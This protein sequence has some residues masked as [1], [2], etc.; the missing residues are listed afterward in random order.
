M[1]RP[2][3]HF[4]QAP[5]AGFPPFP[6]Q[7][8][9]IHCPIIH[10]PAW[11]GGLLKWQWFS[12]ILTRCKTFPSLQRE[13]LGMGRHL[14]SVTQR[15]AIRIF[16]VELNCVIIL[17]VFSLCCTPFIYSISAYESMRWCKFLFCLL[18]D[19]K[20]CINVH[21]CSDLNTGKIYII[22]HFMIRQGGF[23]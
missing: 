16:N 17:C 10:M 7:P 18:I 1:Q 3:A 6:P 11:V 8:V 14:I 15:F 20:K 4:K 23:W 19:K 12:L 13:R 5:L 9:C 2:Y 22:Y 21:T